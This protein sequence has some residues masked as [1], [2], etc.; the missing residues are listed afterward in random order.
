[1]PVRPTKK[2]PS[3]RARI[4]PALVDMTRRMPPGAVLGSRPALAVAL[5]AVPGWK[6]KVR[7]GMTAALGAEAATSARVK[8]YFRH[9]ADLIAFSALIYRS[10]LADSGLDRFWL[11]DPASE[12][13]FREALGQNKGGILLC[14]HLVCHEIM[15][16]TITREFPVTALARKSP[17][18]E[19][20][21]MKRRW[22][23]AIGVELV[24]RP[25]KND[26]NGALAEITTAVRA[27]RKNRLLALTPDLPQKPGTG[28]P[29]TLFKRRVELPAGPFFLATRTGAP[30][31]PAFFHHEDGRY[32]LWAHPP[33]EIPTL[34]DPN[35]ADARNAAIAGAAQEWAALFEAFLRE[36]PDMWQFWLDKRWVKWLETPAR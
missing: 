28:V 15:A 13:L 25:P 16:G 18:P 5:S 14:P 26:P 33:L 7:T 2:R 29:V 23:E 32:R 12:E 11:H 22:Y 10:N 24:Y 20:E 1:M 35:D 17:E 19:Y 30:L 21:A 36:H 34:V 8:G 31:L 4:L 6:A 3:A 9:V 27:L